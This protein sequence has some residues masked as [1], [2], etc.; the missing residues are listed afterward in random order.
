MSDR[1][2][3]ILLVTAPLAYLWIGTTFAGW[4]WNQF[5]C[6]RSKDWE[7]FCSSDRALDAFTD[8][9]FWPIRLPFEI[10]KRAFAKEKA[11]G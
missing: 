8:T 11:N 1:N 7:V 2:L 3:T 10:S 5:E 9:V 6:D 4:A